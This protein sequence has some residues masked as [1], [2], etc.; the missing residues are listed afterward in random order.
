MLLRDLKRSPFPQ[1]EL[2]I[3]PTVARHFDLSYIDQATDFYWHD[4][5]PMWLALPSS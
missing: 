3:H 4:S 1:V 5:G 2:P